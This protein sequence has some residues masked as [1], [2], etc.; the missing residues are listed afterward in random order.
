MI[1]A[2]RLGNITS[3]EQISNYS[4]FSDFVRTFD[5]LKIPLISDK[6]DL[7]V[8]Q[9]CSSILHTSVRLS[10]PESNSSLLINIHSSQFTIIVYDD[11]LNITDLV[12]K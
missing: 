6:C 3:F 9:D 7:V 2:Q 1:I 4:I 12:R 10:K 11:P 5:G 8:Y